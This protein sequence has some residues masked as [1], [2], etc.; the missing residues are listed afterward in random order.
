MPSIDAMP[1]FVIRDW[2]L[3]ASEGDQAPLHVHHAAEEAF[4]C[5]DGHLQVEVDGSRHDVQ[6]GMFIVV[7]RGSIHTFATPGGAHVLVVMSAHVAELVDR[8]H[9]PMSDDEREALWGRYQSSLA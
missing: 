2:R 7:P 8:L 1:D 4:V 9:Q 6:P 5:L 3:E